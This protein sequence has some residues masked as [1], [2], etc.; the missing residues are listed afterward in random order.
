[1]KKKHALCYFLDSETRQAGKNSFGNVFVIGQVGVQNHPKVLSGV[2]REEFSSL[3]S[4]TGSDQSRKH[5]VPAAKHS[6]ISF[7][8]V[9]Q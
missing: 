4:E 8:W 6:K 3:K 2:L 1:M 7:A 5:S 9:Q